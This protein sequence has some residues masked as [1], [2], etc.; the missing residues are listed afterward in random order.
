M[1]FVHSP[2]IVTDGLVLALDAGN[3]KSYPGSGTTWFDK[4]GN[5]N[6]GTLTNGPTFNSANGG[7]IVFDGVDDFVDC[8]NASIINSAV[9][10]CTIN[11]WF[12]QSTTAAYRSLTSK[13]PSDADENFQLAVA[14]SINKLYFD[15]GNTA[16]PYIDT[17]YSYSLNTWYNICVTHNRVAGTS[18]LLLYING[19]NI[20]STTFNPTLTP[21]TNSSN[22]IVGSSRNNT[23]PFPGNIADVNLY[24]RALSAAEVQQ[25]F[26]ALR[27]RFGI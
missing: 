15:V 27:G 21:V 8:G 16:G 18:T 24:N 25:N 5:A 6:N 10:T 19:T 9:N 7:S 3:T 20:P 13:G 11:I 12:K 26:N 2:K 14:H 17:T 4:S 23:L 22:F 1:S